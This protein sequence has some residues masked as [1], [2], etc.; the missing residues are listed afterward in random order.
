MPLQAPRNPGRRAWRRRPNT[1]QPAAT[2]G[3]VS[4]T[5]DF[6]S[7]PA[8]APVL[9]TLD[10]GV[11]VVTVPM[12]QLC[13]TSVAVFVRTGSRNESARLNGISHF[14]EHMAFK[15]TDRWRV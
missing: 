15:G 8:A 4:N 9:T 7:H 1:S 3:A 12:P 2:I 14:L 13:S 11:G 5:P 6:I 10:N